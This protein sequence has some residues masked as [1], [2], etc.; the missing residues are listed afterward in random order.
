MVSGQESTIYDWLMLPP[1]QM[2]RLVKFSS[3]RAS[4]PGG[5][6]TNKTSSAV[7]LIFEPLNVRA[8]CKVHRSQMENKRAALMLL[9]ER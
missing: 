3:H 2:E 9:R 1:E 8:D 5:Q 4:G 7:S 6:K